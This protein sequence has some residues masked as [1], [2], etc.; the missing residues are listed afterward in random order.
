MGIA[1]GL[2]VVGDLIGSGEAQERGIVGETPNLASRLQGVAQPNSVVIAES[3]RKLLGKLFEFEDF[4]ARELKGIDAPVRAWI[5][6]RPASVESRFEALHATGL[7][8]LVGR[9]EEL[10]L[11]LRRWSKAMSGEGQVVLLSGEAGIGKSRLTAA[12]LERLAGEP[13]TRLRYLCSPQ[14][15]DSAFYPIVD[16]F[17]RAL[18]LAREDTQEEKLD[19]LEALVVGQYGRPRE[20]VRFIAAMLSIPCEARYGAAPITPQKF[21]DESL[22]ALVDT[23]EA[24]A[25]QQPAVML[26]EDAH[27]ADPTTL[28]VMDLL[29]HRVQNI[30]LLV[31]VTH[32]PE[33]AV[34]WVDTASLSLSLAKLTRGQS[35][36]LVSGLAGKPLPPDLLDRILSKTDGVPLF[37][38]E[39]TKSILESDAL[40]DT[41]DHWE[42]AGH[43]GVLSIPATLRDSLM[44]RLDRFAPMREVAQIGAAIGREFSYKLLQAVA[45][46]RK[47][48][49]DRAL[50]QLVESALAF[51]QGTPPEAVYAFKH[52]LVQDAA[53]DSLLKQRRQQLHD[54]IA[55]AIEAQSPNVA[56]TEPELLA[57]H[58]TEAKQPEQAIPLWHK[59]ARWPSNDWRSPRRSRT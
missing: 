30:P 12:L 52:A 56:E 21:K 24:I 19:K 17:E 37:V 10:V 42:Y 32:R 53:Y 54:T 22:R 35:E 1:T 45:P 57:H 44:A 5:A 26:F 59:L 55:R 7:T 15:T 41:G 27:W 6:L 8:E 29:I 33:F 51:E 18:Q 3:T 20:D 14:H 23:V 43:A 34:R 2:V 48:D 39:L 36:A 9:E 4:G 11:L 38:E 58:Y 13:H 28:E 49:L 50:A 31:V 16:N 46:H 40:R 47:P 25:R